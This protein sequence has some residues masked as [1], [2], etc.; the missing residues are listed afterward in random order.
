MVALVGDQLGDFTDLF[1]PGGVPVPIR[2]NMATE[3]MIAPLW[4][5]GWF[6]L[7]NPVYGTGLHGDFDDLFPADKRWTDPAEEK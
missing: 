1:N 4:G 2:R 7:P 5:S 3:T 6:I